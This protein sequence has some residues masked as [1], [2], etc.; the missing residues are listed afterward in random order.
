MQAQIDRYY[1]ELRTTFYGMI[2]DML[3]VEQELRLTSRQVLNPQISLLHVY[4]VKECTKICAQNNP[5][6]LIVMDGEED[7]DEEE[8]EE[9]YLRPQ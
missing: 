4:E 8:E 7:S 6:Q 2:K 3:R 5:M 1:S 9:G